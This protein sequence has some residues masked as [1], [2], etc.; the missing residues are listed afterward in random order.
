[1]RSIL[2]LFDSLNRHA[3]SCYGAEVPTPNIDRLAARGVTFDNHYVGSLPCIPA[4][5]DLHTGRLNFLHRSWGPLEPFD[6]SWP[7]AL[8]GAGLCTHLAT[9]HY[10]YFEE[11][12]FGYHNAFGSWEFARGQEKDPWKG[13]ARLPVEE[14]RCRIPPERMAERRDPELGVVQLI[15]RHHIREEADFPLVQTMDM[16]L[17]FLEANA[18]AP[19]WHLTVECFDPHEPFTA[20]PRFR[21]AAGTLHDGIARDWPIYGRV[22]ETPEEAAEVRANYGALLQACDAHLGRL[23]DR[24]DALGAWEDTAVILTTDHG[25]LLGEHDWW[26]KMRMPFYREVA[27][28]PL[29]VCHPDAPA[30]ERRRALTQTMDLAPTMLELHGLD[31]P[32]GARGRSLLPLL[33][34]DGPGHEAVAFGMF[35]GSLNVTDGR[36]TAFLYP[37]DLGDQEIHEHTLMPTH[38]RARFAPEEFADMELAG[39]FDFT[40]GA[41]V[42][43]LV[44]R[45]QGPRSP[46]KGATIEDAVTRLFDQQSDPG[47]ERPVDEPAQMERLRGLAAQIMAEHDAPG[48]A[49]RRFGLDQPEGLSVP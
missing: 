29:I 45:T 46:L 8:T 13:M 28:I 20:P 49:F 15:N 37:E 2:I 18:D 17:G 14:W 35:G 43:R 24:L 12:G 34:A 32:P 7:D 5:R 16:A 9:D 36:W 48:E 23:L 1:M 4:R 26:G 42:M 25:F 10:H 33:A 21:E 41:K 3:L 30:G 11:G 22:R 44:A 40:K 31:P 47:Q 19:D 38:M 27:H 39:P 6:D